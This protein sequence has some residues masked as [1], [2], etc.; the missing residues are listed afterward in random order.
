MKRIA[1]LWV[2]PCVGVWIETTIATATRTKKAK[3]HPAWVCGLKLWGEGIKRTYKKSHPAW[4]CGLKH[5][6]MFTFREPARSHPAWV[7]GL[8]HYSKQQILG[9]HSHT[10]RGC[11]DWNIS[12]CIVPVAPEVTPCVGVWIETKYYIVQND[13]FVVTPCVGVWIETCFLGGTNWEQDVTPCVGVWIETGCFD[14]ADNIRNRS[15]P[16]WVCGLK[17]R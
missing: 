2:T 17:Q 6:K 16:A 5:N 8:K 10:L 14:N 15:H 4:V 11:V 9:T 3:S 12:A 13:R 1:V 7:C